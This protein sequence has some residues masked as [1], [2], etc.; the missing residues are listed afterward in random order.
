MALRK[1]GSRM[2]LKQAL[3]A[4]ELDLL[5]VAHRTVAENGDRFSRSTEVR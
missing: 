3:T 1:V 2:A 5:E 4:P